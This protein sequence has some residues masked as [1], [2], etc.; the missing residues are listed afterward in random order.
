M[1]G[2]MLSR[3]QLNQNDLSLPSFKTSIE[4]LCQSNRNEFIRGSTSFGTIFEK[5]EL[6][7]VYP[8][9]TNPKPGFRTYFKGGYIIRNYSP[10]INAIQTEFPYDIRTGQNKRTNAQNFAEVIVQYM[11]IHNL[12]ITQ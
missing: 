2:Y 3:E 7:T 1:L 4:S 8:S 6:G 10:K 12:L 11:K 5:H 9:L